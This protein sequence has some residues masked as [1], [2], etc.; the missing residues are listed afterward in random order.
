MK[1]K[2]MYK[3]LHKAFPNADIF[4][5]TSFA[6]KAQLLLK[7]SSALTA[8]GEMKVKRIEY[9]EEVDTNAP[10]YFIYI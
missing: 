3:H 10:M 9:D 4:V 7:P 5:K 1:V 2:K 6:E 8:F